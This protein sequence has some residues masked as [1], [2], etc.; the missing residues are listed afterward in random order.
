MT[1][2]AQDETTNNKPGTILGKSNNMQTRLNDFT[3]MLL[4]FHVPK[5]CFVKKDLMLTSNESN[6]ID[7]KISSVQKHYNTLVYCSDSIPRCKQNKKIPLS[8]ILAHSLFSRG[9]E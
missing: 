1:T 5:V 4:S 3:E 7:E 6:N 8:R 2:Q 9:P